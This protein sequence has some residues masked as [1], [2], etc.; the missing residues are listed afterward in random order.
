V[1]IYID[2]YN[3]LFKMG[4]QKGALAEKRQAL[5]IFI[6]HFAAS[7]KK[8][9]NIIVV[10]DGR[11]EKG[12]GFSRVYFNQ[13]EVIYTQDSETAD[14][15]FL[16]KVSREKDFGNLLIVTDDEKLKRQ[17]RE[18]KAKVLGIDSFFSKRK[19]PFSGKEEMEEP[20]WNRRR[21]ERIFEKKL[22][23]G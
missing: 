17:L 16:D 20:I 10:F 4:E 2:G 3:V 12:L 1:P 14:Q 13:I 23:K 6:N 18:K 7:F 9:K 19:T 15:F 11:Q 22:E 21:L 8:N 5:L